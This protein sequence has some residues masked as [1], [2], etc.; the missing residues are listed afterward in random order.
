MAVKLIQ[1][2]TKLYILPIFF[3]IINTCVTEYR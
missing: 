3:F 2:S 1:F